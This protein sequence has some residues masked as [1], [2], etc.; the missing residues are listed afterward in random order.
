LESF[1]HGLHEKPRLSIGFKAA[2][3]GGSYLGL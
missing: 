1:L 3:L 2:W